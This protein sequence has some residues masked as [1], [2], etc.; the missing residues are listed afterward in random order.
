MADKVDPGDWVSVSRTPAEAP[1]ADIGDWVSVGAQKPQ[2]P[3]GLSV[4]PGNVAKSLVNPVVN[5]LD[6]PIRDIGARLAAAM[7]VSGFWGRGAVPLDPASREQWQRVRENILAGTALPESKFGRGLEYIASIPGTLIGKGAARLSESVIGKPATEAISPYVGLAAD[8]AP[9]A[10]GKLGA[11]RGAAPM[12]AASVPRPAAVAAT[13]AGYRLAPEEIAD[14]PSMVGRVLSAAS[15]KIKK[16]QE[17]SAENQQNTNRLAA[18]SIGLPPGTMLNSTAFE[19]AREPAIQAYRELDKALPT[20]LLSASPAYRQAVDRITAARGILEPE[21]T[22]NPAISKLHSQLME[23]PVESIHDVRETI[24][25]LRQRAGKNLRNRLDGQAQALGFAQRDA[26]NVLEDAIERSISLGPEAINAIAAHY[27]AVQKLKRYEDM[28]SGRVKG[29]APVDVP[30]ARLEAALTAQDVAR[31]LSGAT[32][33]RR[34]QAAD[35]L[36]KF[37]AAR[38]LFARTYDLE[39]ATNLADGNVSARRVAALRSGFRHRPLVGEMQQ[40]ANSYDAFPRSMQE[41]SRTGYPEDWS[42]LDAYGM[43]TAIAAGHPGAALAI[44]MRYPLRR[45]LVSGRV[46]RKMMTPTRRIST[47]PSGVLTGI[48]ADPHDDPSQQR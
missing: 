48:V 13:S 28:A 40:I 39:L 29:G 38:S 46:Q 35:L 5:F 6:Y 7:P 12:P 8:A 32:P 22:E 2:P 15:G 43:G 42:I 9:Y 16:F 37:R 31:G 30:A 20:I 44:G 10:I 45:A 21:A 36:A 41:P 14:R 27:G 11:A 1:H 18:Q 4:G 19:R 25:D 3:P 24:S 33:M 34:V 17:L 26:A 23:H 47:E